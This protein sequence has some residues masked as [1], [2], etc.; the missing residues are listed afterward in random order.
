MAVLNGMRERG[1]IHVMYTYVSIAS[2]ISIA[3]N[4]P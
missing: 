1:S 2:N 4:T 3:S